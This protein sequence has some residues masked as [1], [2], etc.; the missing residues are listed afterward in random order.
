MKNGVVRH[1]V[2]PCWVGQFCYII[3][4]LG[5]LCKEIFEFDY[6][7]KFVKNRKKWKKF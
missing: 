1:R 2:P 5:G 7:L 3:K 6:F 4:T